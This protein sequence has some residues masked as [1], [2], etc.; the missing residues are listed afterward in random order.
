VVA[1]VTGYVAA[2]PN[3]G[4]KLDEPCWRLNAILVQRQLA[5]VRDEP[6]PLAAPGLGGS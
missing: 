5:L 1:I 3:P 2:L 4:A 6:V